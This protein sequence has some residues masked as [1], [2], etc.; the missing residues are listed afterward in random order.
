[1]RGTFSKTEGQYIPFGCFVQFSYLQFLETAPK[2]VASHPN[3]E[4]HI[5]AHAHQCACMHTHNVGIPFYFIG[6]R[7]S[8]NNNHVAFYSDEGGEAQ[9]AVS[10]LKSNI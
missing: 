3:A 6:A 2:D 9:M 7:I 10:P 1:M 4:P 8:L 5:S